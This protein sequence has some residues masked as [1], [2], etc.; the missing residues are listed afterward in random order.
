[1]SRVCIVAARRTPQGRF[2]GS[3]ARLSA[4]ELALSAAR[5]TLDGI[6]SGIIESVILGNV[7]S[8]GSGMNI[9]RQLSV[10][11]K[12]P[13]TTSAFT[14]NM[15]CAS[16]MQAIL[17]GA[18][19]IRAGDARCILCG[20]TESMSNAPF[21]LRRDAVGQG[22]GDVKLVDSLLQDGLIDPFG[23][24]HM[25]LTAERIAT[26]FGI[27]RRE[28]DEYAARSQQRY[29]RAAADGVFDREL[30]P[31]AELARDEHPRPQTTPENLASLKPAFQPDGTVT[32]G[33]AS[34]VNDGA[35]MVLLC[36]QATAAQHGLQPLAYIA[37]GSAVG[38]DP[39][40]MGL[41]P[42]YATR[43]LCEILRTEPTAF[44]MVELNEAFAA[45]ALACVRQLRLD[46]RRVNPHGGAIAIGHPIGAS[47]ARLVVHL[48]HRLAAGAATNAL[49]SLCVGGGMGCAVAL[50]RVQ[51]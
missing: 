38:C 6:D 1:M 18:Q 41:G 16:G 33:N 36:D 39:A 31:M 3:L 26:D 51:D 25:G 4:V 45:Q 9:A 40:M 10:A 44:D 13:I 30:V 32:A 34:G 50:S 2:R 17:L 29:G 24:G 7:L 46:E 22:L 35:A 8:A 5:A 21:L 27:T 14:V 19:E 20:G 23:N 15:M 11:L 49:A 37:G 47:G 12:L 42:V 48:A 43:R 28:Q